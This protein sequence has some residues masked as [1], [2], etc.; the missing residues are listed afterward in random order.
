MWELLLLALFASRIFQLCGHLHYF[1]NAPIARGFQATR[2]GHT[3][4][5]VYDGLTFVGDVMLL[6]TNLIFVSLAAG[7]LS[8]AA[9]QLL[10]WKVY[11]RRFFDVAVARSYYSDGLHR[12][13]RVSLLAYD[14][15]GQLLSVAFW[16][17]TLEHT[18]LLTAAAAGLL[19][20]VLSTA[21]MHLGSSG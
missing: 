6:S 20:Y 17:V 5:T 4:F 2:V 3:L 19:A 14:L 18:S 11:A 13:V 21:G 15:V 1:A 16:S 10:A 7:H 8:V 12:G 9:L